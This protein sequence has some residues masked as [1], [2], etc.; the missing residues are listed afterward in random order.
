MNRE[1]IEKHM[2]KTYGCSPEY[3]WMSAP[4][5]AV[6]RHG[7]NKKWFA[8]VMDISKRK[9]GIDSDEII[10]IMNVKCDPFLIGTLLAEPGFFRAYHMNKSH[11]IR[12]NNQH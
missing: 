4:G 12:L 11:W 10:D 1:S 6:Y 9:L 7:D 5:Y 2:L 3:P 8:V